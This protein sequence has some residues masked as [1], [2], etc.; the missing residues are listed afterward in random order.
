MP[1]KR[2]SNREKTSNCGSQIGT[3]IIWLDV[4]RRS[5]GVAKG[6]AEVLPHGHK[7]LPVCSLIF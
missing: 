1:G 4:V 5:L 6:S 3:R 2:K 7:D